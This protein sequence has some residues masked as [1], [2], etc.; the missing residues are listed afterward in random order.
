MLPFSLKGSVLSI[1]LFGLLLIMQLI[2]KRPSINKQHITILILPVL[3]FIW[4][5]YTASMGESDADVFKYMERKA[6][7]LFI[8]FLMVMAIGVE[9]VDGKWAMRGFISGLTA[10]GIAILGRA[11][12][13]IIRGEGMEEWTYHAILISK[14]I[15]AIYYSW[16]LSIAIIYLL[17]QQEDIIF[18]RYR[19]PLIFLFLVLLLMASSKL[20]IILTIPL[21]IWK[22]IAGLKK[23]LM[24]LTAIIFLTGLIM[25]GSSPFLQRVQEINLSDFDVV[26]QE[27]FEYNTPFNGITLRLLQWRFG[28]EILEEQNGFLLGTGPENSQNLLNEKYKE[29]N[30]YT[31][32]PEWNSSGY[33][34]YNFHNQ[35]VET[36]VGTGIPGLVILLFILIYV[37]FIKRKMIT[38]PLPIYIFTALFF[39][40][41]SV[42]ERQVG[43]ILF[44]LLLCTLKPISKEANIHFGNE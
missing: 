15:G 9:K 3:L 6:A 4:Y 10:S 18:K 35:Y 41:E 29:Y 24:R 44:C 17:Y 25:A 12:F 42:L 14:G 30:V 31:G 11:L 19:Y 27:H 20:F 8:P 40:T 38:F 26:L 33:L 34:N 5:F 13:L 28:Y 39:M 36:T 2:I 32:D 21:T 22:L 1:W 7:L 37:L 43:I 16:F 23:I